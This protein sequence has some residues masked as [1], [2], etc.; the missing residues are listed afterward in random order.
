[1]AQ[2]LQFNPLQT[3]AIHQHNMMDSLAY[4]LEIARAARNTQLIELLEQEKRQISTHS[5][6][7]KALNALEAWL[8][9]AK[10][11]LRTVFFGGSTLQVSE[12]NLGS[13]H[14]WYAFDP[15]TGACVYADSEVELRLWIKA[16]Y[17]GV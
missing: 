16:N 11:G 3:S 2:G 7:R 8:E 14:W 4:R 1:M 12:F 10:E 13:D 6:S 17:R 15:R 5:T 9:A